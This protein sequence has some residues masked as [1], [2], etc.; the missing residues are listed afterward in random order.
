MTSYAVVLLNWQYWICQNSKN[1][2]ISFGR[3]LVKIIVHP[4]LA[5]YLVRKI[6]PDRISLGNFD[7][8]D[9]P[10]TNFD[11]LSKSSYIDNVC[12]PISQKKPPKVEPPKE[13]KPAE[14]ETAP[15]SKD[16][17]FNLQHNF[18]VLSNKIV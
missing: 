4:V 8:Q 16:V 15:E 13:E 10:V 9:P 14:G 6:H 17:S 7:V 11:I 2:K 1:E 12:K 18:M 5:S 3:I